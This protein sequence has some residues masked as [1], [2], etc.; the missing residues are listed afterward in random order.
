MFVAQIAQCW[1]LVL[2]QHTVV[3]VQHT[4]GACAAHTAA[5]CVHHEEGAHGV[6]V[7]GWVLQSC[8]HVWRSVTSV[9]VLLTPL[10]SGRPICG[11]AAE[12][13]GCSERL[14]LLLI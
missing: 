5:V 10:R 4:V 8:V 11:L 7:L 2:V 14:P 1:L 13:M 12:R 6:A 9:T 3:R